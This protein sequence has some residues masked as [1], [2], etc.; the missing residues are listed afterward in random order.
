MT[1]AV[2]IN[3]ISTIP[4]ELCSSDSTGY[5]VCAPGAPVPIHW[6]V[7]NRPESSTVPINGGWRDCKVWHHDGYEISR[8]TGTIRRRITYP[9]GTYWTE[10][11]WK[12]GSFWSFTPELPPAPGLNLKNRLEVKALNKLKNQDIHLGNFIAQSRQT[13]NLVGGFAWKAAHDVT[14]F[15]RQFPKDWE[16]VKRIQTGS[17]LKK[18]WSLIPS[19]WLALQYGWIPL[20][21]DVIGSCAALDKAAREPGGVFSV[22]AS[23]DEEFNPVRRWLAASGSSYVDIENKGKH[24]ATIRLWY[25]LMNPV[26]AELSSLGLINPLECLWEV[27]R[28][29]FILDWVLPIGEWLSALTGDV[30]YQFKGGHYSVLSKGRYR[31]VK[32]FLEDNTVSGARTQVQGDIVTPAGENFLFNRTCYLSSPVPGVYVKNP[33]SLAHLANGLSLL[34]SAL[35]R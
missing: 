10:K 24:A 3:L 33:V 11:T 27:A 28:Y 20:M 2:H 23:Y 34:A 8:S 13:V 14:R 9:G 35:Q 1:P 25:E 7:R 30:G 6:T 18:Y 4:S 31:V 16:T 32:S 26:L 15:Q 5:N 17:L 22:S 12:N 21:S 29:S 19:R